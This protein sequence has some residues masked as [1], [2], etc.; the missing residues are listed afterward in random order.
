VALKW[1]VS[2]ASARVFPARGKGLTGHTLT[3]SPST[4]TFRARR[5]R[6]GAPARLPAS[7]AART[8]LAYLATA[9]LCARVAVTT[10]LVILAIR[11]LLGW[12][13]DLSFL[14]LPGAIPFPYLSLALFGVLCAWSFY[15]HAVGAAVSVAV[16][17]APARLK[18]RR[19]AE[20]VTQR[21]PRRAPAGRTARQNRQLL[22]HTLPAVCLPR[23]RL[24]FL[25]FAA[26]ASLRIP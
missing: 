24:P 4:A 18:V 23:N 8:R 5:P 2:G 6:P 11:A 7:P 9:E 15:G 26:T 25:L 3:P 14:G 21:L 13:A 16:A 12:E 20:L 17:L 19:L 22:R 1:G 10:T